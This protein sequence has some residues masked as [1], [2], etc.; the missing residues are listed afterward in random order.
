MARVFFQN[1]LVCYALKEYY[2]KNS[3]KYLIKVKNFILNSNQVNILQNG[4][5][6]LQDIIIRNNFATSR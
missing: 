2:R 5:H 3:F 6:L 1:K 4:L